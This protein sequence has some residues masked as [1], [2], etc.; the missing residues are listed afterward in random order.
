MPML[1]GTPAQMADF[2]IHE[3]WAS[4]GFSGRRWEPGSTVTY[5]FAESWTAAE[6]DAAARAFSLWSDLANISFRPVAE[7]GQLRFEKNDTGQA[8]GGGL[9]N[10]RDP[11]DPLLAHITSGLISIDT[12]IPGWTDLATFGEYG[13]ETL[14]HEIGHVLGLGHAGFYDG[15]NKPEDSVLKTDS[16]QYTIMSYN[17]ASFTGADY[18]KWSATAPALFDIYTIQLLYGANTETRAGDTVYGFNSTADRDVYDFSLNP[19]PI[20]SI[21]DTGGFNT[22]DVSGFS[23]DAVIDLRDGAFSSVAGLRDNISI[24]FGTLIQAAIGGS[25]NDR[26]VANDAS[27][28]LSGGAGNDLLIGGRGHDV[29]DGGA[30]FDTAR[31][32]AG[33]RGV[34]VEEV[35][36][37]HEVRGMAQADL[38][39]IERIW[40]ADGTLDFSADTDAALLLRLAD[41]ALGRQLEGS[42]QQYWVGRMEEGAGSVAEGLLGSAEFQAL[43]GGDTSDTAFISLLYSHLREGGTTS[44]EEMGYWTGQLAAGADRA[45]VLLGFAQSEEQYDATADILSGGLWT[46]DQNAAQVARLYATLLGRRPDAEGLSYWASPDRDF[47]LHAVAQSLLMSS[48]SEALY[49]GDD[50]MLVQQFYRHA[51]GRE[52]DADGLAYWSEGLD[53]ND[54]ASVSRVALGISES[55]EHVVLSQSWI[56]NDDPARF[57]IELSGILA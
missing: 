22:L 45:T 37:G 14:M 30:G 29:L 54:A 13:F 25:G 42:G 20:M 48:E 44:A 43:L 38:V 15:D 35:A 10:G 34:T 27:N 17:R 46:L 7:G 28:H 6:R 51:L 31:L 21:Y 53:T 52:A 50:G 12:T 40:L 4:Q 9:D 47:D 18:G 3:Y 49:S 24:A 56:N 2:L 5:S 57:G 19:H 11:A 32:L 36:D 39:S 16:V 41:V 23:Q 26:L 1:S 33:L 8:Y 55:E